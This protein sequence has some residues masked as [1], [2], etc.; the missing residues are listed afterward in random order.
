M[1]KMITEMGCVLCPQKADG[2]LAGYSLCK[3]C[4]SKIVENY[5]ETKER[6][7]RYDTW[8][9]PNLIA[10]LNYLNKTHFKFLKQERKEFESFLRKDGGFR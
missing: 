8:K 5:F 10:F 6:K 9:R 3:D 7:A 4:A 1:D 2:C